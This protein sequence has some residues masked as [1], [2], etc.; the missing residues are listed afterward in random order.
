MAV[1]IEIRKARGT[2]VVRSANSVLAET[3]AALELIEG[4]RKPVVYFPRADVAM[5]LMERS[6]TTS[7]CPYKGDASYFTLMCPDGPIRDAAWSYEDPI[8]AAAQI[9]GFLAFYPSK[10][11]IEQIQN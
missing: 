10:V 9:G 6:Q 7:H 11:I 2:W 1:K 5:E 3:S 8:E 4:D